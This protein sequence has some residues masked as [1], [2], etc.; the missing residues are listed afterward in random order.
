ME[1]SIAHACVPLRLVGPIRIIGETGAYEVKAPLATFESPLWPSV[2]RGAR[3]TSKAGGISAVILRDAMARSIAFEAGSAVRAAQIIRELEGR[4]DE[5]F[6]IAEATSRFLKC[7]EI[8]FR[9][10]GS[11]VFL[12]LSGNTGDAAGHNMIT[13]GADALLHWICKTIPGVRYISVSGN[14][15]TDK[16]VSSVNAI[17]GRGKCVIADVL[18]P[19]AICHSVLKSTPEAIAELNVKKNLLGSI[20]NGGV[21]SANAHFANMLLALYIATGQ[22]GAN[23]VEGSQG[24]CHAEVRNGSLYFS[25]SL[26]NVI[27]GTVGHGKDR[28]EIKERLAA[29]G[30]MEQRKAGQN[31]RRLAEIVAA[32]VLCGELNL[33]A[34]Q[35]MPGELV[36]SHMAIERR[37]KRGS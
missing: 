4:R 19:P 35:T 8:A 22:D 12:R 31:S 10:V 27:V 20:I 5:L 21:Q 33:L 2:A 15:C 29:L 28:S 6:S 13:K 3:A 1:R 17:L 23:T 9:A 34:A 36:R 25:V 14:Y 37:T 32:T 18:I 30:C 26:P 7:H 11:C 24:I 16:K